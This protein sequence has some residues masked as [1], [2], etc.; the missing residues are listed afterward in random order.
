MC[1]TGLEM[2]GNIVCTFKIDGKHD[3]FLLIHPE[4]KNNSQ[5]SLSRRARKV[6]GDIS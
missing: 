4:D 3:L 6:D 1:L 5:L 2:G